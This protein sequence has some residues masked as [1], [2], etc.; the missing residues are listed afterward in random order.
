MLRSMFSAVSGLRA[1]QTMM[2]VI[3][4]NIANVNTAGFKSGQVVFEDLLSQIL[5]GAGAPATTVGG[6]NPNQVGLGVRLGSIV[7]SFTQGASQETGRNTDMSIQGDGFF[8]TTKD[9]QNL[10]TRLGSFSFDASGR[11]VTPDG[12]IVQ[13]W[14]AQA[15]AVNL[16]A[17]T[18]D[19]R[20]PLGQILPPNQTTTLKLGGNMPADSAPGAALTTSVTVYDAQGAAIPLTFTFTKSSALNFTDGVTTAASTTLTSATAGF[21]A[22]D[23]GK[24]ITGAGIPAGTTIAS[25]TNGTTVVLSQAATA[26]AAG[27]TVNVASLPNVWTVAATAPDING[28]TK[29]VAE[30]T[31]PVT[32]TFNA[33]TGLPT[34]PLPTIDDAALGALLGRSFNPGTMTIDLGQPGDPDALQ[35][36]AGSNS[37]SSLSQDGAAV[38]FLRS[39]SIANDGLITGVFSNGKTESLGQIALA[40]FNNPAGLL[41]T[42][43]SSYQE[44]ANSGLPQVGVAGG[45]GRGTL[46]GGTLEMSNVDL[47]QEFTNLIV[48]QRGFEANSKVITASD[49]L[50][51]DLVNL[52]R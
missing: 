27:V 20:I 50:L 19:L 25:V 49:E 40:T 22:A 35:Q 16:N 28:V 23:V 14:V 29:S 12:G 43:N 38:G 3:G 11:L 47:A 17:P 5:S 26:T 9:G 45:G 4:N 52:K 37:F 32:M 2:D 39:F 7:T 46:S 51:Q 34:A 48:A 15:G 41:K 33:T 31:P 1:H 42:G 6:T 18:A 30:F 44:S 36:F 13:G 8:L 24:T 21:T 10:Y